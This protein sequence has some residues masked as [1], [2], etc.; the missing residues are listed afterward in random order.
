MAALAAKVT[1]LT[2]Y[3]QSQPDSRLSD[4]Q[5][6]S[7]VLNEELCSYLFDDDK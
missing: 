3:L 7:P 5:D 4:Q 1:A 2:G 6:G